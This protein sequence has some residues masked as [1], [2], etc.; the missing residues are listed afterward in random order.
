MIHNW[1]ITLIWCPK[2]FL[3]PLI[4]KI[5]SFA[6]LMLETS[7]IYPLNPNFPKALSFQFL[8]LRT[9]QEFDQQGC[10]ARRIPF[11][12]PGR[13]N[14]AHWYAQIHKHTHNFAQPLAALTYKMII[15]SQFSLINSERCFNWL[16]VSS[17][18]WNHAS[19]FAQFSWGYF[20]WFITL[21]TF[22]TCMFW[23]S[24]AQQTIDWNLNS[25]ICLFNVTVLDT[26]YWFINRS[27]INQFRSKT[28]CSI[29]FGNILWIFTFT[30]LFI[31]L[32]EWSN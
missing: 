15:Q 19:T 32:S 26:H 14:L 9:W 27:A 7:S 6:D 1:F 16:C 18:F 17:W 13:E 25:F 29:L 8:A 21:F 11:I 31:W 10:Q 2:D 4:M 20:G 23:V 28:A 12:V 30:Y 5:L 24:V 3:T 22:S